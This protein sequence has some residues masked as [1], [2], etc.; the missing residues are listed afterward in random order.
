MYRG[1]PSLKEKYVITALTAQYKG[2]R[3][4]F[5][6]ELKEY[7]DTADIEKPDFTFETPLRLYGIVTNVEDPERLGRIQVRFKQNEPEYEDQDSQQMWIPYS[8]AYTGKADGIVFCRIREIRWKLLFTWTML[9]PFGPSQSS[10]GKRS[11][12][13]Q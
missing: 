4:L 1:L 12:Q 6:Y 11:G 13:C 10:L 8:S 3:D 7:Q 9:C 2:N 5:T